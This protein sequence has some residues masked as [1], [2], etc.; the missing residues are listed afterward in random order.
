MSSVLTEE[1]INLILITVLAST[2]AGIVYYL[3]RLRQ[4][5]YEACRETDNLELLANCPF[6]LPTGSVRSTLALLIVLFAIGYVG[7]S[8]VEEP[9]QFLTAI[10]STVLGFYFGSRSSSRSQRNE[11]AVMARMNETSSTENASPLPETNAD[12]DSAAASSAKD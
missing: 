9:P 6:G 8:G 11:D 1:I 2:L 7:I 4:D 3:Y 12:P 5:F 10:V